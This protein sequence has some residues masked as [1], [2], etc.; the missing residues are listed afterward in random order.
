MEGWSKWADR[1][2][3]VKLSVYWWKLV[4]WGL[5]H[6]GY[7]LFWGKILK[8]RAWETTRFQVDYVFIITAPGCWC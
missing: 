5:G 7:W 4:P 8:E 1:R 2:R 3:E 6:V